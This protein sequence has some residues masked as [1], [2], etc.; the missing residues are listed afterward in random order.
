MSVL[1]QSG[2]RQTRPRRRDWA[3]AKGERRER[4]GPACKRRRGPS[5][6]W[7]AGPS[8]RES[9]EREGAGLRLLWAYEEEEG[10]AGLLG[11]RRVGGRALFFFQ[12]YFV[13]RIQISFEFFF[14]KDHSLQKHTCNSMNAPHVSNLMINFNLIF[15]LFSY[16]SCAQ[17]SQNNH[18]NPIFKSENFRVLQLFFFLRDF[19]YLYSG[20]CS[21][22]SEY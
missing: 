21:M 4:V 17:N 11:R 18:F 20:F 6:K 2:L 12:S 7:L 13:N 3:W 10:Q 9:W 1:L 5:E 16:I 8:G 22:C 19:R 15:F 14:Y